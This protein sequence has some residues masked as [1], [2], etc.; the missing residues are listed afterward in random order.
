MSFC[1][2]CGGKLNPK[3][4]FCPSCGV[5]SEGK[6]PDGPSAKTTAQIREAK[7]SPIIE[8]MK[9]LYKLKIK[10]LE[11]QYRFDDFHSPCLTDT[12][13]DAKPMV[14]LVGQYSTG[15][16]TFIKYLLERDF[17][18]IRIGPEPTTD[19]FVAIMHG[20]DR[21]IPGNALAVQADKPFTAL[22]KYGMA[23]L[24]RFECSQC[25]SPILEKI[26]FIDTPGVLSGE[27]QRTARG[28]NFPEVVE[29]FAGRSDRILLLFDAHKL[30]ISDEFK[31]AIESLAGNDDKIRVILNKADM[32]IQKLMRV[33]G[34]L[35]WSLGKV[36]Q[37]PE[38]LRVYIGSFWDGPLQNEEIAN[39]LKMEHRDLM[40]DLRSLPRNSAV[41]KVNELVKRSRMAKVHAYICNHM[42]AQFGMFGKDKLQQK[43]L[44]NMLDQFKKVQAQYNLPMGDFPHIQRFKDTMERFQIWKFPKLNKKTLEEMEAVLAHDLPRL[45]KMLPGYTKEENGDFKDDSSGLSNPFSAEN[46]D[47]REGWVID[48]A[49]QGEYNAKY[50]E[51]SPMGQKISGDKARPVLMASGL[52]VSSLHK[53]W[54]LSDIDGD[55]Y[56]DQPE[57]FVACYLI[58]KCKEGHELPEK[59][60][61]NVVPPAKRHLAGS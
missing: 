28:Y 31:S 16:T 48:S 10:P 26:S 3:S 12:D 40:A 35:M 22:Q 20:P 41:R 34:A 46:A 53:L 44:N 58:D 60:P 52:P 19:R 42:R 11:K 51:L 33:Y 59:L 23:F 56:L 5:S 7:V 9:K 49:M 6:R 8:G 61:A 38:V 25:M 4:K 2:S 37:T 1:Q 14:M 15:K 43:L 21:V 39:L 30:D 36:F 29:W 47:V 24:N 18:G 45:M 13:F 27:K 17:L 55:G 57:F 50:S 54:D 32:P